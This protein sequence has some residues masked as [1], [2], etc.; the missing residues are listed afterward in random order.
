MTRA[1]IG[2]IGFGAI[3][4]KAA[5]LLAAQPEAPEIG[6]VLLR[7]GSA[8]VEK[9]RAAGLTPVHSVDE[10][11]DRTDGALAEC[12]GHTALREYGAVAVAAGRSL[13]V[14]SVGALSDPEL[15][16]ELK[17]A[18]CSGGGRISLI[19]GAVGGIDALA[20]LRLAGLQRVTYRGRKPPKAWRDSPAEA[21]VDLDALTEEARFFKGT[22][23]EAASRFP[24]NANVAATVALA[25]LGWEA[26]TA[27]LIADPGIGRNTHEILVEGTAGSFR[28]CLEGVPEPDNPKTS[29]LTSLSLVRTILNQSAAVAV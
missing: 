13:V 11:L 21:V 15:F 12:A 23:R 26:T 18:A 14:T 19:P 9:V 1:T 27:E 24:K 25:G 8:S 4:G 10:L 3:G 28:I 5:A 17:T 16:T 2:L 6:A 20:A 22:A 29:A 7:N